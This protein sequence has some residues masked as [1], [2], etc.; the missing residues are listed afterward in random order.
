M[1]IFRKRNEFP[2][3]YEVFAFVLKLPVSLHYS[4]GIFTSKVKYLNPIALIKVAIIYK[5]LQFE[6]TFIGPIF[7]I[8]QNTFSSLD[9]FMVQ[10]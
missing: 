10:S 5:A 3:G 4:R 7:S 2:R 8:Y 6:V 9:S 1:E